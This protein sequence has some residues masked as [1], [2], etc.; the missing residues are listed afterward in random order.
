LPSGCTEPLLEQASIYA[1]AYN[2]EILAY[3][4]HKQNFSSNEAAITE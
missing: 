4:L 1:E 2:G 3:L